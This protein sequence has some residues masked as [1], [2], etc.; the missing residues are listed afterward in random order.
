MKRS[1]YRFPENK[2]ATENAL[3]EQIEKCQEEV[4]ELR[5]A[6]YFEEG[7]ERIIEEAVDLMVAAEGALRKFKLRDVLIGMARVRIKNKQR[8]DW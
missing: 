5:C 6:Y 1:P 2:R 7:D 3:Y 4:D 8:G